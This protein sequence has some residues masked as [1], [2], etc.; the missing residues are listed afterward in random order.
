MNLFEA[1]ASPVR[2][3]ILEALRDA[4]MTPGDLVVR[5]EMSQPAVS[6]HLRVLLEAGLVKRRRE[7][8]MRIY[9][10][11]P[12]KIQEAIDYLAGLMPGA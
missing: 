12:E 11:Q 9:S 6:N 2:R 4:D 5:L 1:L 3:E 8:Q 7:R 10:L